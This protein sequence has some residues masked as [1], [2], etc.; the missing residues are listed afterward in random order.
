MPPEDVDPADVHKSHPGNVWVSDMRQESPH[1]LSATFRIPPAKHPPRFAE[2]M[3]VQRQAGMLQLHRQAKVAHHAVLVLDRISLR[4]VVDG[5]AGRDAVRSGRVRS[6][7]VAAPETRTRR[8]LRQ[9]FDLETEHGLIALG[10]S[11]VKVLPRPLYVRLRRSAAETPT[12]A[13]AGTSS[14]T[15]F[16]PLPIAAGDP[17]TSDHPSDHVT[18]MQLAAAIERAITGTR[19]GS[20]LTSLKLVFRAY[21]ERATTPLV[22]SSAHDD[23][24]ITGDVRQGGLVRAHFSA[25][26]E[27]LEGGER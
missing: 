26:V 22:R 17:L 23:G 11:Q 24:I 19:P 4:F 10:R 7:L 25:R 27:P 5:V 21:T 8:T 9:F 16:T 3:E 20:A 14:A 18:A 2:L 15:G 6:H 1:T 13:D 12:E